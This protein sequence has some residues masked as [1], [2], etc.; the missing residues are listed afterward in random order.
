[1]SFE[2]HETA[3]VQKENVTETIDTIFLITY[4]LTCGVLSFNKSIASIYSFMDYA[5]GVAFKKSLLPQGHKSFLLHTFLINVVQFELYSYSANY[6]LEFLLKRIR[7]PIFS[8]IVCWKHYVFLQGILL[9][10][11]QKSTARAG[12]Q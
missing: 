6:G 2:T 10:I 8:S 5:F 4:V 11:C 7:K 1:M 12:Q 9:Q 3:F